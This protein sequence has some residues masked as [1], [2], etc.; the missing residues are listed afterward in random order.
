MAEK[1]TQ[2]LIRKV[3]ED[4]APGTQLYDSE[5]AGLRIV[6]GKTSCSFK[7]VGRVNDGTG[8]YVSIIVG[9]TDEMSLVTARS[10]SIEL[11]QAL[12][13]GEDPRTPKSKMPTLEEVLSR[14]EETRK[15]DL[16]PS[17]LASYRS[18]LKPVWKDLAKLPMDKMDRDTVRR[19]HERVTKKNGPSAANHVARVLKLLHNDAA[20]TLDLPPN[21]ISR[22][23][24]LNKEHPR[25]WAISGE[26]MPKL[27]KQLD[28]MED[29]TRAA[30]WLLML[31]TGLRCGNARAIKWE[32]LSD[33]GTLLI[34]RA[35]SGR[36][37]R[38]PLPRLMLQELERVRQ[39]TRP[40]CSPFVFCSPTSKSGHIEQMCRST[41]FPYAPHMM[42][43]SYRSHA[44]EAGADF[45]AIT[46]LM[47]HANSHVSFN[48]LT[49]ANIT[50]HLREIQETICTHLVKFRGR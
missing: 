15:N 40:L 34:P 11:R 3:M 45:T 2:S 31:T 47:D 17:T 36:A 28:A 50:G 21:P 44:M 24:R 14:Y 16:Q 4:H 7:H 30:C 49:R 37:F 41:T 8:R 46:V 38:L 10:R 48:Y 42:R 6:V 9:R 1:L 13:R 32:H 33:D 22:A 19:L 43:H 25:Q 23:V 26:D 29:R 5:V 35:K 12:A 18:H 20:R 27:W 39:E